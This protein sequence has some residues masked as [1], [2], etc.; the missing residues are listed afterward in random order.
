MKKVIAVLILTAFSFSNLVARGKD[1]KIIVSGVTT[2][3]Q[4]N[5][6]SLSFDLRPVKDVA[7]HVYV[8]VITDGE[9]K[10]S[11]PAVVVRGKR[12]GI[13]WERHELAD[14]SKARFEADHRIKGGDHFTYT[15]RADFQPW[16]SGASVYMESVSEA[17]GNSSFDQ[18]LLAEGVLAE[19]ALAEKDVFQAETVEQELVTI[20][21]AEVAMTVPERIAVALPFI[22][23]A[24]DFNP[25]EPVKFYN[26][27]KGSALTV[28]YRVNSYDIE[29]E[30]RGN[31][32]T[33]TNL[34]A[35]IDIINQNRD[36]KVEYV[37]IAGFASPEGPSEYNDRL[38]WERAISIKEYVLNH[39]DMKGEDIKLYNGSADWRGLRVLIE[40]DKQVPDRQEVL[41]IIDNHPV[42]NPATKTG[43]ITLLRK[44]NGGEPYRY[45]SEN[46]LPKLRNGAFIRVYFENIE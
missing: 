7:T 16:M 22:F 12:S 37:V 1:G 42:W 10:V 28:Y 11:F 39:T 15:A 36:S 45:L 23:P 4:D 32:Q 19:A 17:C 14:G 29:P 27:D 13:I 38:A 25:D 3:L 18:V 44:L 8:P 33:L 26:D 21:E 30:Y 34:L 2:E 35:S 40:N 5:E 24:S 41:D 31:D 6:I 46:I 43:R 20:V 9:Y